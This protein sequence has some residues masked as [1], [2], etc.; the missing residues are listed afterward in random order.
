[1]K[2]VLS[3]KLVNE[4]DQMNKY[5]LENHAVLTSIAIISKLYT[6][7]QLYISINYSD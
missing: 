3:D 5:L 7:V 2:T 1:M 6:S 4:I